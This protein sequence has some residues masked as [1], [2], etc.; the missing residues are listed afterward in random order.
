M[1]KGLSLCLSHEKWFRWKHNNYLCYSNSISQLWACRFNCS[2]ATWDIFQWICINVQYI[3]WYLYN[4]IYWF[5][6]NNG[7]IQNIWLFQVE[8]YTY[9]TIH[10][11]YQCSLPILLGE[12]TVLK[13]SVQW[14]TFWY[15][16]LYISVR[17]SLISI[18]FGRVNIFVFNLLYFLIFLVV[19]PTVMRHILYLQG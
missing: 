15:C 2:T 6:N 5:Y 3:S 14:P 16:H 1:V 11:P 18:K 7:Q 9:L 8:P 13:H 10:Y 19:K 12:G 17:L 4:L